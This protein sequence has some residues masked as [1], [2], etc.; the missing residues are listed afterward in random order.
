M[1]TELETT[2]QN[3]DA[4]EGSLA[5]MLSAKHSNN[6]KG[7]LV[8]N[9]FRTA[10]DVDGRASSVNEQK[11]VGNRISEQFR[12]GSAH[13]VFVA[14]DENTLTSLRKAVVE[15]VY[16][17]LES[18]LLMLI[19]DGLPRAKVLMRV[20]ESEVTRFYERAF[21]KDELKIE[22]IEAKTDG[23]DLSEVGASAWR[24]FEGP[25]AFPALPHQLL[26][27]GCPGS[28]KS[29]RLKEEASKADYAIR[30]VFSSD[31][32]Y[33]NFVGCL[34][35]AP[36]YAA[37]D[38]ARKLYDASGE[39]VL[40]GTPLIDYQFVPG[41][42]VEAYVFAAKNT[43]HSV[44][45]IIEEI[46]RANAAAAFGDMIQLLDRIDGV[47]EY[48][49]KA[50]PD[51]AAFL[52]SP[53]IDLDDEMVLPKNLFFWGTM[54]RADKSVNPLDSAFIRRWRIDHLPHDAGS[55]LDNVEVYIGCHKVKWATLRR[56]LNNLM[57]SSHVEEDRFLGPYFLGASD[58]QDPRKV[59]SK[60]VDYLWNDALKH[61]R[62]SLFT[63]TSQ[64]EIEHAWLGDGSPLQKS[65][66]EDPT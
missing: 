23:E 57:A 9:W 7:R 18:V 63:L 54:N 8:S 30:T 6:R 58:V 28:G 37:Y 50:K 24:L 4:F 65:F 48:S 2:S 36:L 55:A 52:T 10:F 35:P 44:V 34:R 33:A 43:A 61:A 17:G 13:V 1:P 64:S 25:K 49:I 41:P 66:L 51:L 12:H 59:C 26:I 38:E 21:E 62:P 60:L 42:F 14:R 46:S 40:R 5:A 27:C 16:H 20:K 3:K 29:F 53:E 22:A 15:E 56:K 19:E 32:S 11:Q 31:T 47:S 45:L 39:P